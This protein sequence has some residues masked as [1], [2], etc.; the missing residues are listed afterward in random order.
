MRPPV[1]L[2]A[3]T[4][5][6]FGFYVLPGFLPAGTCRRLRRRL[7]TAPARPGEIRARGRTVRAAGRRVDVLS[8]P[9]RTRAALDRALERL[10][11]TLAKH[12]GRRLQ[13][14]EPVQFLR[15]RPGGRY[16]LHTDR[17]PG[18]RDPALR[19]RK[20]SVVVFLNRQGRGAGRFEGGDLVFPARRA[21]GA[22]GRLPLAVRPEPGLLIAFRPD[23][24]HEVTPVRSGLRFSLAAWLH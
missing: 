19:R 4:F 18:T 20:V 6:R 16:G 15:Y 23:L 13:G 11:G 17:T 10:Q 14:H 21:G 24:E 1:P 12:F 8:P 9:P 3:C 22:R 7:R 2:D 5:E